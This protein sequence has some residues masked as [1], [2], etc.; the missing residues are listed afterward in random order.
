M[1][2]NVGWWYMEIRNGAYDLVL[3]SSIEV[4]FSIVTVKLEVILVSVLGELL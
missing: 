2:G 1:G 3:A 4:L